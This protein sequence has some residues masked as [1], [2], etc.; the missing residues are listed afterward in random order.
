MLETAIG[1]EAVKQAFEDES[2][3]GDHRL[4][5]VGPRFGPDRLL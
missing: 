4:D 2:D 3:S 1:G 5:C